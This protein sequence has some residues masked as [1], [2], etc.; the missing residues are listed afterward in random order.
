MSFTHDAY[1]H[2][3]LLR[4]ALDNPKMPIAFL[5]GAGCPLSIVVDGKPLIP[6]IEGMTKEIIAKLE[7]SS[8]K[9]A[10]KLVKEQMVTPGGAEPNIEE[11]LGHVRNLSEV[12]KRV[13]IGG[14]DKETLNRLDVEMCNAVVALSEAKLPN[15][16]TPYHHLA[17]WIRGTPRLISIE[18]FTTNYDLLLEQAL[19][20]IRV[21]YFDG[22][23]GSRAAFFDPYAIE[24]EEGRL[25]SRWARLWKLHGSI[26]WWS[27][28]DCEPMEVVRSTSEKAGVCRL[29]HPSHLKYDESRKMPYLAMMDRLKA[30]LGKS[31]AV[32]VICGYSFRDIHIN[33][34]ISQSLAGNQNAVAFGLLFGELKQY[35][36]AMDLA[37]ASPNLC[38]M[39]DDGAVI[40][41]RKA[42]WEGKSTSSLDE[43]P[44]AGIVTT[45]PQDGD[46]D[47]DD[48]P[49]PVKVSLG[50]FAQ[51]GALLQELIGSSQAEMTELA[52]P[53][54]QGNA[55]RSDIFGNR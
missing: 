24:S 13:A 53:E 5:L 52:T 7:S 28:S 3:N 34:L 46:K 51:L 2:T 36:A 45:P 43:T 54:D 1:K 44:P 33:S 30:F 42:A 17:S 40:G 21:P 16:S 27:K 23:I 4:Q 6:A 31:R 55:A 10:F 37:Q 39:A 29:I 14:L 32:L 50:D 35:Q 41:T 25:P 48:K 12:A 15:P 19:E 18:L 8:L 47:D 38:L 11:Y 26:N 9:E 20:D 22:F 49:V